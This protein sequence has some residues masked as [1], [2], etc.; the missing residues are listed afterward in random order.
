MLRDAL[1]T[2]IGVCL[3]VAGAYAQA[4]DAP[5]VIAEGEWSKPVDDTRGYAVR[6]RLVLCE[7]MAGDDLRDVA[8]YVELQD[9]S[10]AIGMGMQL[11]CEMGKTD[12]SPDYKGGLQCEMHDKDRRLVPHTDY[13][14]GGRVPKSEWVQLPSDATIRLRASPFGV[15]RAKAMSITP[16]LGKLWVIADGDPNEYF[17]SGTFTVAPADN[18]LEKDG[19]HIW[20][21]AIV[22]PAVRIKNKRP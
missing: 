6:G 10:E 3:L 8:V 13:P 5:R 11:F 16:D 2:L 9:A 4:A 7:K 1:C 22:L 12:F 14:F 17:L 21:G 15:R 19:G 20:R 18:G